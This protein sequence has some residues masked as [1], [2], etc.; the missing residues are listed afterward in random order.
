MSQSES[1]LSQ[2]LR[3]A[4][5]QLRYLPRVLQLIWQVARRWTIA[6]ILLLAVEGTLP[7][8]SVY[9]T[10]LVVDGIVRTI[11][12][13]GAAADIRNVMFMV[14]VLAFTMLLAEV[15]R[16]TI[17]WVKAVQSELLQDH[18]TGLIHSK[19]YTADLAF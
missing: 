13:S 12:S 16:G 7:A 9:L 6:W 1:V 5:G 8:A 3:K 11:R 14:A 10:K 4:L 19:S 2:N 15:I 18:I 17:G